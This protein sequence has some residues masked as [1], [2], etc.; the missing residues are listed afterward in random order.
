MF[1]HPRWEFHSRFSTSRGI[2]AMDSRKLIHHDHEVYFPLK[3]N[4]LVYVYILNVFWIG[5]QWP[6]NMYGLCIFHLNGQSLTCSSIMDWCTIYCLYIRSVYE[7]NI[8]TKNLTNNHM[9][10]H[11]PRGPFPPLGG[12]RRCLI[13]KTSTLLYRLKWWLI[14]KLVMSR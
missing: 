12:C 5:Y 3:R 8:S 1:V 4:Q 2:F 10:Y 6:T 9:V 7:L 13:H 11:A 14:L